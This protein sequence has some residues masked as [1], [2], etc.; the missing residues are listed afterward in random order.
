MIETIVHSEKAVTLLGGGE[1]FQADVKEAMSHASTLVVADG[2][3]RLAL[4]MGLRPAA[5]IGDFDTVEAKELAR[6]P[7]EICHPIA[8][9]DSTD[10]EKCLARCE[11]PL[12]LGVGFMGLRRDHELAAFNALVRYPQKR[13][14][15][16]GAEDIVFAAPKRLRVAA[17][18]GSR[19]S[20]F[21]MT[22]VC[23]ESTGLKWP[24]DGL[25]LAPDG[26][27]GTSNI[28]L[29]EVTLSFERPGALVIMPRAALVPAI[30]ALMA[31]CG[32]H[33]R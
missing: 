26:R 33:D 30:E 14:V 11:A 10:F 3:A 22:P 25:A 5:V 21:P 31:S 24:I 23:G 7:A 9:Q 13:C 27:I 16:I 8:E 6:F 32:F 29:G 4:E 17:K 20:L 1:A 19:L 2:G 15:L 18:A 28:A 12:F